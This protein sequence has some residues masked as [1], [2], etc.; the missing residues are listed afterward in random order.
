MRR[1]FV[2]I[3]LLLLASWTMWAQNSRP[4]TDSDFKQLHSFGWNEKVVRGPVPLDVFERKSVA[5]AVRARTSLSDPITVFTWMEGF[6]TVRGG[7]EQVLMLAQQANKSVFVLYDRDT[8]R[9]VIAD[10]PVPASSE[11]VFLDTIKDPA[12]SLDALFVYVPTTEGMV[13]GRSKV[14]N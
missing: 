12:T 7:K 1:H 8:E 3:S 13:K 11:T 5:A 9:T 6:F 2:F 10:A 4:V 14:L